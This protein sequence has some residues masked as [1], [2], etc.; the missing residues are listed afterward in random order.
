MCWH[1]S[2]IIIFFYGKKDKNVVRVGT[3]HNKKIQIFSMKGQGQKFGVSWHKSQL[4]DYW[5]ME[6]SMN[7]TSA[8]L[9]LDEE[10][11]GSTPAYCICSEL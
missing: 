4:T 8:M 3:N 2:Q 1:K 11:N 7:R 6:A 9:L 10:G 5:W